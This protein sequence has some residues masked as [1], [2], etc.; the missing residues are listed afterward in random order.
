MCE[1]IDVSERINWLGKAKA[2]MSMV[3]ERDHEPLNQSLPGSLGD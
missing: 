3:N 2:L 1:P